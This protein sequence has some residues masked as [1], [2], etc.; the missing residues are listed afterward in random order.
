MPPP[1]EEVTIQVID[2]ESKRPLKATIEIYD[3]A[4]K[5]VGQAQTDYT[6]LVTR[7]VPR[8]GTYAVKVVEWEWRSSSLQSPPIMGSSECLRVEEP[9][10]F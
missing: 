4:G 9:L 3:D 10:G 2:A 5:L 7:Q 6:G 1:D 8:A